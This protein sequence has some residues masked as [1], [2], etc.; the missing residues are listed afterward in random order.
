M[1]IEFRFRV[2]VAEETFF[3]R[4]R[5]HSRQKGKT[6]PF[7]FIFVFPYN[8]QKPFDF[9]RSPSKKQSALTFE[10]L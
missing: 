4:R 10:N 7:N 8:E 5:S 1:S 9:Y 3:Q 2:F 6:K